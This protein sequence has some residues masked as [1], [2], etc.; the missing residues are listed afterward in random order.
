MYLEF[1]DLP[2]K[3]YWNLVIPLAFL[4]PPPAVVNGHS[5]RMTQLESTTVDSS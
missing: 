3:G 2:I 1:G 5:L 4:V